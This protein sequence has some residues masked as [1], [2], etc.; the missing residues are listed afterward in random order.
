MTGAN[1]T[2]PNKNEDNNNDVLREKMNFLNLEEKK[3]DEIE[4]N[5]SIVEEKVVEKKLKRDSFPLL[6][7]PRE[8]IEKIMHQMPNEELH[9]L[10]CDSD[11]DEIEMKMMKRVKKE[12]IYIEYSGGRFLEISTNEELRYS[13]S[14]DDVNRERFTLEWFVEKAKRILS[15]WQIDTVN[16]NFK[17][18]TQPIHADL[19][20]CCAV[21]NIKNL[22]ID[23]RQNG[24]LPLRFLHSALHYLFTDKFLHELMRTKES[25][26]LNFECDRLTPQGIFDLFQALLKGEQNFRRLS[27]GRFEDLYLFNFYENLYN[28]LRSSHLEIIG[29]HHFLSRKLTRVN[30]E[31]NGQTFDRFCYMLLKA[32]QGIELVHFADVR[33]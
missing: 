30:F 27:F 12:S 6:M 10:R 16:F 18:P 3:E 25:V 5:E 26:E 7:L 20:K 33:S 4:K 29:D 31:R 21:S 28:L 22:V 19:I 2:P 8:I 23:I 1:D 11:L 24:F 13:T 15:T 32:R 14:V 17:C 9:T